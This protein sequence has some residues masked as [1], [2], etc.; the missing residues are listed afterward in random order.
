GVR[1]DAPHA[2]ADHVAGEWIRVR[3]RGAGP[4]R[5]AGWWVRDAALRRFTFPRGTV[6]EPGRAITVRVGRGARAGSTFFWGL[7]APA[8][9]N[10]GD[11]AYL[12]DR[13][14]NLRGWAI[15]PR[16]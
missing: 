1:W 11:G 7:A 16:G 13:R 15:Y 3:N 10:K 9:E 8:F 2:D 6:L 14:A 12:F 4:V 5:L